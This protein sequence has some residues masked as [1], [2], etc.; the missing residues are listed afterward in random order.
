MRLGGSGRKFLTI[1]RQLD[2]D[3]GGI[4]HSVDAAELACHGA[5]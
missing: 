4:P 2:D 3:A 1:N 5:D